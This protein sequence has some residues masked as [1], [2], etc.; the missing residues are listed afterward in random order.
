[1]T[2]E[3]NENIDSLNDELDEQ[4]QLENTPEEEAGTELEDSDDVEALKDNNRKLF[5]RAKKAE[6]FIKKDGQWVKKD[7]PKPKAEAKKP[8]I[9]PDDDFD[10]RMDERLNQRD[11]NALGLS[12]EM[13]KEVQT[14]AKV[15]NVSIQE[16]LNLPYIKYR[17][18]EIGD[19]KRIENAGAGGVAGASITSENF[20][21]VDPTKFDLRTK[22]G[23]DAKVQ[24]E[25]EVSKRLG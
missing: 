10:K 11:L 16:A 3:N 8:E 5:A 12:D 14:V 20:D 9:V 6:G 15:N 23:Q 22:E 24:W 25:K 17:I 4:D 21:E 1:M 19:K 2:T 18:Q 7:Q 13:K